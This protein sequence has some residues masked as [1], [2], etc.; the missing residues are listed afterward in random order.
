M[1]IEFARWDASGGPLVLNVDMTANKE[2]WIRS[3]GGAMTL[4]DAPRL[5]AVPGAV[6]V[7]EKNPGP[8]TVVGLT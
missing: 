8:W 4:P 3:E 6:V 1:N 2:W 5:V 7:T